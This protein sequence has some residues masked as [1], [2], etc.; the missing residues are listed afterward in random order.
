[1]CLIPHRR[2]SEI[3]AHLGGENHLLGVKEDQAFSNSFRA[4]VL[5]VGRIE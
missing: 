1:M 3:S 5:Y 4:T 2:E